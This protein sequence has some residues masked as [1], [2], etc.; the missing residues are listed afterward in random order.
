MSKRYRVGFLLAAILVAGSFTVFHK[1]ENTQSQRP[2]PAQPVQQQIA[3]PQAP[4]TPTP[5]TAPTGNTTTAQ[6]LKKPSRQ[7][8]SPAAAEKLTNYSYS[9]KKENAAQPIIPGVAYVS[10]EGVDIKLADKDQVVHVTSNQLLWQ[11]S[12]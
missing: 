10:G 4:I 6:Q 3:A 2:L 1:W 5:A 11:K 9:L 8:S 7:T 12:F